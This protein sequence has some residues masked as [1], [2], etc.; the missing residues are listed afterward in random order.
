MNKLLTI[1]LLN[2]LSKNSSGGSGYPPDWSQIGF[3]DTP[4]NVIDAFNYAK[5][6]K[7]NWD[8]SITSYASKYN[9]NTDLVYMPTVD[10][11][12]VT[13]M[14][15]MFSYATNLYEV[16]ALDTSN[17]TDMKQM[18]QGCSNLVKV[19]VFDASKNSLNLRYM[20]VGC[21]KLSNESLNNIMATCISATNFA[22]V[23]TLANLGLTSEQ[24]TTCQ[25]LSNYD[26][27][28]TAGWTT[29]Y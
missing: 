24:A 2:K 29:G 27:F 21:S 19:P 10:T 16:G 18:F 1:L 25:G 23:K 26:D 5:D 4:Q 14:N 3:S 20:F 28:I 9:S 8:S 11:S 12:N 22:S 13:D 17:V 6:I 15:Q 7:D